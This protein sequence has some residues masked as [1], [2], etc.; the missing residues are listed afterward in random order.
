MTKLLS[1]SDFIE[2]EGVFGVIVLLTNQI[3]WQVA[4][5]TLHWILSKSTL[6]KH[7]YMIKPALHLTYCKWVES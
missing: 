1:E 3:G 2:T 7:P 6:V 4:V 5:V